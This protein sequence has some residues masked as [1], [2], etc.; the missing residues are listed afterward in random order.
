[1]LT[2]LQ[3]TAYS[4][5]LIAYSTQLTASFAKHTTRRFALPFSRQKNALAQPKKRWPVSFVL[6]VALAHITLLYKKNLEHNVTPSFF[7]D[8]SG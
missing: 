3:F 6:I 4:L 8:R 5:Q 7:T 1:M 2:A